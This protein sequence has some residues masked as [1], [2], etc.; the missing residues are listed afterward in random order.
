MGMMRQMQRNQ[1]NA[2]Q[3]QNAERKRIDPIKPTFLRTESS[4]GGAGGVDHVV[5][6][7]AK[8]SEAT[9]IEL[10]T[11]KKGA[12]KLATISGVESVTVGETINSSEDPLEQHKMSG[13]YN[14]YVRVRLKSVDKIPAFVNHPKRQE[15]YKSIDSILTAPPLAVSCDAASI[16]ASG[17]GSAITNLKEETSLQERLQKQRAKKTTN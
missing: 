8:L 5:L 1:R 11:L 10:R 9:K 12:Q 4:G 14:Y 13:G 15:W 16:S 17:G 7:K 6:L 3:Q 2:Q